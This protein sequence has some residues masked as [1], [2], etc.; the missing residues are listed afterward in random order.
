[1]FYLLQKRRYKNLTSFENNDNLK[2][3]MNSFLVSNCDFFKKKD[4]K[5]RTVNLISTYFVFFMY[6]KTLSCFPHTFQER[7]VSLRLVYF[8]TAKN[9]CIERMDLILQYIFL[10]Q[11][12][13]DECN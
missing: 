2:N 7:S 5:I 8:F 10:T 9:S 11:I 6:L 1:M 12:C 13:F 4:Y 3:Y